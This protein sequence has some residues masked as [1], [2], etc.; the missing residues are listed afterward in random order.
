M[1]VESKPFSLLLLRGLACVRDENYANDAFRKRPLP[2][3][4]PKSVCKCGVSRDTA[5]AVQHWEKAATQ[6]NLESRNSLGIY[7][8]G[9]GNHE[10][11]VRHFLIAA[12]MGEKNALNNIKEIFVAGRA[13]KE[14]YAEALKG[15][16]DSV[17]EMKSPERDEAQAIMF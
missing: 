14:Q 9:N 11:A 15:Y 3:N 16:Q 7:E 13:T 12:K 8:V 1:V 5:K 6:G 2:C 17:N 4:Q 10:R